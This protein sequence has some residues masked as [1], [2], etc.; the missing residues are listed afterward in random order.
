MHTT[1]LGPKEEF[2]LVRNPSL[3]L[4]GKRARLR[5]NLNWLTVFGWP[6]QNLDT[7]TVDLRI[8]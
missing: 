5:I 2:R 1:I 6:E 4:A 8:I 3:T 7:L